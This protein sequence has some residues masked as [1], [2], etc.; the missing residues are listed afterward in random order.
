MN[1]D[2]LFGAATAM[3]EISD[4]LNDPQIAA[5]FTKNRHKQA[6]T[7]ELL[8]LLGIPLPTWA[9]RQLNGQAAINKAAI[10]R[11]RADHPQERLRR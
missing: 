5:F 11:F 3:A 9:T 2:E 7:R 6:A 10:D 8:N 1:D 4:R